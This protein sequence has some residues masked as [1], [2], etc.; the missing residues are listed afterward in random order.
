MSGNAQTPFPCSSFQVAFLVLQEVLLPQAIRFL[1]RFL[2]AFPTQ[3]IR[4]LSSFLAAFLVSP[5]AARRTTTAQIMCIMGPT[6]L[7]IIEM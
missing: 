6:I 3:E 7:I 2:V 1:G 4:F 5:H